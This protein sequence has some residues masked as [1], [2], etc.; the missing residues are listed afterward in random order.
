VARGET[1]FAVFVAAGTYGSLDATDAAVGAAP[2][3]LAGRFDESVFL[4]DPAG[5]RS[6][7]IGFEW[8]ER[9]AYAIRVWLPHA[10]AALDVAGEPS[11]REVVRL[12]LDRHRAAGVHVY[13]E[14]AD[15]RWVLGTGVLRDLDS[16]D[17]LGVL[18]AGTQAWLDDVEQPP[19][20]R[21]GPTP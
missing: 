15:P 3:P 18:V 20:P 5:P 10:F 12:L 21:T 8:D 4:P 13:V 9:E 6:F 7:E 19:P 14:Y 2:R 16:D 11:L 1:R 17:A